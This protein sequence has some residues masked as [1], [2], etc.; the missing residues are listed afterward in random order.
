MD[1]YNCCYDLQIIRT[2]IPLVINASIASFSYHL[3]SCVWRECINQVSKITHDCK[4]S[5]VTWL[6]VRHAR[7]CSMSS[8]LLN[9]LN[10]HIEHLSHQY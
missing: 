1:V 9:K 10:T 8:P 4:E 3:C 2:Q 6:Y 5:M 7:D